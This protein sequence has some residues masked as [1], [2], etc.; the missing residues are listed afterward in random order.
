MCEAKTREDF[1]WRR[2]DNALD[3]M[4]A[5]R[6]A[7]TASS[8]LAVLLLL[9]AVATAID[10]RIS[11]VWRVALDSIDDPA[12]QEHDEAT[13]A[14]AP[15]AHRGGEAAA[16]IAAAITRTVGRLV[17]LSERASS[18][19]VDLVPIPRAPPTA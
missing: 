13:P 15:S 4:R 8:L 5:H 6:P 1:S 19:G 12:A 3:V 18:L 16:S 2:G 9:L 7:I 17:P 14:N 11:A 10:A